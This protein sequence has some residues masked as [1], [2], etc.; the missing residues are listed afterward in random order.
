M[1]T[2]GE[3]AIREVAEE[4]SKLRKKP[5][6]ENNA[7]TLFAKSWCCGIHDWTSDRA[8]AYLARAARD[9]A[10]CGLEELQ[11]VHLA[12]AHMSCVVVDEQVLSTEPVLARRMRKPLTVGRRRFFGET[13]PLREAE[14]HTGGLVV[15]P[16]AAQSKCC[17]APW[18]VTW[19][20]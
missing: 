4:L 17:L 1:Q 5:T 15:T 19:S 10:R 11:H 14:R 7:H 18:F 9:D 13:L 12:L 8:S 2:D 6:D 16:K 3:P 20:C